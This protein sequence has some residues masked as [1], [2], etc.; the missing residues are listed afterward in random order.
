MALDLENT[1]LY[2]IH[3]ALLSIGKSSFRNS[4]GL[5]TKQHSK[6]QTPGPGAY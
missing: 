3:S 4:F 1:I 6:D 5:K 2:Q